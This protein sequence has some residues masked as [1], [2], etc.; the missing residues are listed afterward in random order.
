MRRKSDNPYAN[1]ISYINMH[2]N[3]TDGEKTLKMMMT[4]FMI[5]KQYGD[6][7]EVI[8][9]FTLFVVEIVMMIIGVE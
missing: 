3:N 1:Y 2:T 6:K 7:G 4:K 5:R 9:T 8:T